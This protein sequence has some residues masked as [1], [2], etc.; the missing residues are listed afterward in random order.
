MNTYGPSVIDALTLVQAI[1]SGEPIPIVASGIKLANNLNELDGNTNLNGA[2]NVAGGILSLIRLDAALEADDNLAAFTAGAEVVSY[3]AEAYVDFVGAVDAGSVGDVADFLN[4]TP[5]ADGLD[6]TVG[7][8]SYLRLINAIANGDSVGAAVALVSMAFPAVGVAYAIY[9]LIDGLFGDDIPDPWGNSRVVWDGTNITI[10]SVGETGGFEA[11]EAVMDGVVSTMNAIIERE[12]EQNPG[13]QLGVIPTRMPT[14]SYDLSGFYF[15]NLDPLTGEETNPTLRF[16]TSGNPYNAEPGSPESFQS[17]IEAMVRSGLDRSAI[18]PLWEVQTAKLQDDAGDPKAGLT[19]EARAGRDGKLADTLVGDTQTF[20]PVALDLDGDGI[21]TVGKDSS[22]VAFDVDNSGFLKQTGWLSG[23]DAFLTLDRNYNGEVDAGSEMFSNSVVD[24]SRRGLAGMAWLDA[25]YDGKLTDFDPVWEELKVWQDANGNGSQDDGETKTLSELGITELNYSLSRFVQNGQI[26]QLGSPDLEADVEGTRINA[27]EEGIIIESSNGNISLL[28]TRIDDL[29][30]VEANRDGVT[31]LED[32]EIIVGSADLLANDT[33]GGFTGRDLTVTGVSNFVNGT[34][35]LDVNGFVHFIPDAEYSG[36]DAQ[37]QYDVLASNGQTGTSTVD[38]T[39]QNVNDAPTLDHVDHTT[40]AVYGYTDVSFS[41]KQRAYNS[42]GDPI[43]QPYVILRSG[44]RGTQRTISYNPA[45]FSAFNVV[46]SHLSPISNMDTGAGQVTGEDVD[47]PAS[48]LSYEV[49]GQPQYGAVT[50]NADGS[51]QYTSWKANGQPGD[52]IYYQGSYAAVD[53]NRIYNASSLPSYAV[54]PETDVFQV[55][56]T[57]PH[58]ASTLQNISVPHYGPYLPDTPDGGGGKKPIAIDLDGDGFE[59]INVDDSNVFFDVNGDGWKQKISWVG[60]DDGLLAYDID[61]DGKIDQAG[62]ISFVQYKD[63]AQTDLEGLAA[64]DTN[65]DGIFSSADEKWASFGIWQDANQDGVTDEGELRSLDDMGV[66]SIGLTS[67][68][69]FD[70]INGQTIHG[71]GSLSMD[72]GSE[73]AIA[74]VS[75]EYS[76]QTVIQQADGTSQVVNTSPFSPSGEVIDGTPDDDLILGKDGNNIVNGYEGNDVIFEDG[77]NDVIYA[78]EG[79]DTVYS[80]ADN[81]TVMADAGDDIVYA[82]LADDIVFGED[83]HDAIFAEAGNDVAFGGAGNDLIS[84]GAGNDVLSG[85]EGN[86]QVYGESGNDG[87]FGGGGDDELAGMNGN[88]YLNGG[89]GADLLDGGLGVDEMIGGAGDDTYTVDDTGDVVTELVNEGYDT[90]YSSIDYNIADNVED[91]ILTGTTDISGQGNDL[92]NVITGNAGNNL[93]HGNAG[94]D[95]I[96]GHE[97]ADSMFGGQ[98]NDVYHVDNSADVVT[99]NA[100][101][102]HDKVYSSVSHTLTDHVEDIKLTGIDSIFSIGNSLSNT[103]DGNSADNL[104][105]G[106]AGADA[107]TGGQGNDTYVVD[108]TGDTVTEAVS[109]GSDTVTANIV[110]TLGEN[111]E[112]L[113]LTGAN[114]IQGTGN[115]LNNTLAGN[116]ANNVLLGMAGS[117][118]LIGN[119]GDDLL[120]G[121]T[122]AD[123]MSGGGGSDTYIVDETNDSISENIGEGIDQ[124]ES[125]ATYTLS[126]NVENL[127]LTGNAAVDG[128]GNELNNIITGN[129]ANNV[130]S[131]MAGSDTLHGNAGEDYLDGGEGADSMSGG[132]GDDTYIVENAADTVSESMDEGIDHIHSSVSYVLP[133]HVEHLTLTGSDAIDGTGNELSNTLTGNDANNVLLGMAGSDVLIGNDGDDLLDGGTGADAMSG[134]GGSDTYI[135]DETNDSISENIGEGIDQVESSATYTLSAN[136]EN[137][138]LT[139]NAAVDGTG[140]ELNNIITGNDANN[141]LSGMAGS[142][143]LHGNAGED[144]LDG[145]EGADSMSGGTGDD[146]YIVENAADTVSESMDEGIDHIHSSVSYVLPAHVEHLTLTG[147]DAIDGT[148]NE[149][150]NTLTGNDANNVLLGMAGSDVLIG[151]DG[152]DLLDGGTGADAMSGGGGSDTYIVDETN[153]SISENIGEGIDQ[154]ESSATYTLSANVENLAL[155]GNAAVDGTGNELNNIITGNDANNVLSGMAGSDTLHGNAGEDYLDGGE[156]ADSMSGGTGDD[157]Y[158]VENAAD[159]VSESM[160]EGIDHIHSSVSYVLPAHVEHLTLTGSDA[161]D[162]TGNELSN[163]LTGNDANNVLL[164]MAGSDVLIGNDGDDLLDG[165]TGADAMSGGGGS[166]TYIVDETN[167]SISENIGEGIDQVES[168]ATYTLSANVENL[169][170]TGNAAVDGTGNELNN[171]ITGNDANNVLSGMAGSDTLHGNAGEDYL[172]GG[173]GADSMSG[174]TGDDTYIVENAADTVSESMD[175]GIDHIHSSVSYVLPA[176]VEHLTLTGS[177]AIDGTGNELSNT[178]TG[179]DANNVL[180]GM[181]GSDVLIGNDGDDVLVGG[182]DNDALDGGEGDDTYVINMEDGLDSISDVSGVDTIQFG[183]GLSLD[184]VAL[185]IVLE[186]G[187]YRAKMRVLDEHGCEQKDQGFNFLIT[188]NSNG[189]FVSPIEVFE[190]ID[191]NVATFDDLLV[192]TVE[193]YGSAKDRV[194]TTGR[195]DDI[196]YAGPRSDL[197]KTGSGNDI[198]YGDSGNDEIFVEG[199]DDT[200]F[201]GV[202]DDV[203]H[204]GCGVDLLAGEIG[205]DVLIDQSGNNALLGGKQDDQIT[206]GVNN[207]FIA[208]GQHNDTISTGAGTNVVAFNQKDG[209]DTI[210]SSLG[211]SNVLSLGDGISYESL[212]FSREGEAL[213]LDVG[214]NNS[215]SFA[216]WY[217]SVHNQ[218]FDNLQMINGDYD[219]NHSPDNLLDYQ[220]VNFDFTALVQQFD[221]AQSQGVVSDWSLMDSLLDAHLTSS[222]SAAMGGDLAMQYANNTD[223][224][225]DPGLTRQTLSDSKF[226]NQAQQIGQPLNTSVVTIQMT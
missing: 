32:I 25:N 65:G 77:G 167:D 204:G 106:G 156:G 175:E 124:V 115:E 183:E 176:H 139:G 199:G 53:G 178:L 125:S 19:E 64:F 225:A 30:A 113:V 135:V 134:G 213:V 137:L 83:G 8:L 89:I 34:G 161:I 1:Q 100:F 185:R 188:Q 211:A 193:Y 197:I 71:V 164:G 73:L 221:E 22:G 177:D 94:D 112:N 35:F 192:K 154:V 166:D 215:V 20:R 18:A 150:S 208:G 128:T 190:F 92:D 16:D 95:Q 88:D 104:L 207:D 61:G 80:G 12:R 76:S 11:V 46:S 194:I 117:D 186:S 15:V 173:E 158:I 130:L 79:D 86:D 163:T 52:N 51:F 214:Q 43:Y 10:E 96:D 203:I 74:D 14:I 4:G 142:D 24:L 120:D 75:L 42:G 36:A 180:L 105:D 66:A 174:G 121:G 54:Y 40:R 162:G 149:L 144:Y 216:D 182:L 191:G 49:V 81:D 31:G 212:S 82:G 13:S 72:D 136:V 126:A 67:D 172:D 116:D 168:S 23:D 90:V 58:G 98:G 152:D 47:D 206:G 108:H 202:R 218:N 198:V 119:D 127:A 21:E 179:N 68:G 181:A 55:K 29:T 5:A 219:E 3:A 45:D 62:E 87:L 39:V 220:V 200:V 110:Y 184:N 122:G 187:E 111:L 146:T 145:G 148:G 102:G 223:L 56:I 99:E 171:I 107:M 170:L 196:I 48:S 57:D 37:F 133:A 201:G 189:A 209:K 101:E 84:G 114:N 27:I 195:D 129:D 224:L 123:A 44:F 138:A 147:S 50:V 131:G 41:G 141:V 157:T 143:T 60:A 217:T 63:D 140:N 226:G 7:A 70:I 59:F 103:L 155:T 17:L 28:V 38:V 6:A 33:L 118:V 2:A 222:D 210:L 93:L 159:T 109:E 9:N 26:R 153:D 78:G 69:Q 169:A 160:D 132:T 151:N 205:R 91:L 85:D 165:G 97:G